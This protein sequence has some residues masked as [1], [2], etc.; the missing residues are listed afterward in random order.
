MYDQE[1]KL[2]F[3]CCRLVEG[4]PSQGLLELC[5]TLKDI[6]EFYLPQLEQES[7]LLS[8]LKQVRVGYGTR[9]VRPEFPVVYNEGSE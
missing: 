3:M 5:K 1:I 7:L 6:H 8:Q 4:V 9:S 2:R